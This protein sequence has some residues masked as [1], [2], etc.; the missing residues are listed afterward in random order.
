MK[1]KIISLLIVLTLLLSCFSISYA[2]QDGIGIYIDGVRLETTAEPI[3]MDGTVMVPMRDIF[4]AL[5]A[6][7][8]WIPGDISRIIARKGLKFAEMLVSDV[9]HRYIFVNGKEVDIPV[10][11]ILS[12][13]H[14]LVP[15][16]AV[17]EALDAKV[18][19]TD[20]NVVITTNKTGY[21]EYTKVPDFGNMFNVK[22]HTK[23]VKEVQYNDTPMA[24]VM[25]IYQKNT[26]PKDAEIKYIEALKAVGFD[27]ADIGNGNLYL[28]NTERDTGIF[29]ITDQNTYTISVAVPISL[30]TLHLEATN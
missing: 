26:L 18:E 19:W 17:A 10:G 1:R 11:P 6:T 27:S 28:T 3:N 12:D 8:E 25:Y 13:G 2:D 24:T 14:T 20:G 22:L 4:E 5:G 15:A 30:E 23:V 21:D 9:Q 29:I 16:R 7:V